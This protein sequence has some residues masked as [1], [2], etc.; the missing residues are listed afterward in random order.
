MPDATRSAP[1][2]DAAGLDRFLADARG[3]DLKLVF[4]NGCFDLI[5]PGHVA[6][7]A[8]ARALGDRLIVGL[9]SDAGI[10]RLKG[11]GRPLIPQEGRAAVLGALRSV[12]AVVLFDEETP[13]DLILKVRP[14]VLVKGGDYRPDEVVGA[15]DL[16]AW[17]GTLRIVPFLPGHS[18]STIIDRLRNLKG[19][20]KFST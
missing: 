12:D 10:R 17:G 11:A 16:P 4:T 9:N 14:D 1:L 19:N 6:Y 7:L 5:H 3:A 2:L 18:T 8:A 15:G 20:N 13:R